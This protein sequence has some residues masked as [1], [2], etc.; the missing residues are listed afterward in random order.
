MRTRY[1]IFIFPFLRRHTAHVQIH[2]FG[3]KWNGL[4]KSNMI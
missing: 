1:G 4:M 2:I 3:N